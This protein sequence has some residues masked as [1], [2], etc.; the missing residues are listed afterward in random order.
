M[1][2]FVW[3][4]LW[5]SHFLLFSTNVNNSIQMFPSAQIYFHCGT[6]YFYCAA[7]FGEGKNISLMIYTVIF[8][9]NWHV[10]FYFCVVLVELYCQNYSYFTERIW[11]LFLFL[12]LGTVCILLEF[13][14]S[15]LFDCIHLWNHF[16]S[17]FFWGSF[18]K[19]RF[20]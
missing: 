8:W 1:L 13:Y 15:W 3:K 10:V 19:W 6:F 17:A 5:S 2:C 9:V 14:L 11:K 20:S 7:E 16:S 12:W 18:W 4:I